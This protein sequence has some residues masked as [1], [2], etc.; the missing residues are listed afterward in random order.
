VDLASRFD[1]DLATRLWAEEFAQ[2][3]DRWDTCNAVTDIG[4]KC[5]LGVLSFEAMD[6]AAES[7]RKHFRRGERHYRNLFR[8]LDPAECSVEWARYLLDAAIR[9]PV[10][11]VDFPIKTPAGHEVGKGPCFG[12]Q[13]KG[14]WSQ[15]CFRAA[16][17]NIEPYGLGAVEKACPY[18]GCGRPMRYW[19]RGR[20]GETEFRWAVD[21]VM[22]HSG[23]GC[24]CHFN[25]KAM[26]PWCNS[27]KGNR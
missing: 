6:D 14:E 11:T 4:A 21:H 16:W 26:H 1:V 19:C 10:P 17:G 3:W 27:S 22:S 9:H 20:R 24:V 18:R 5:G 12:M 23:R 8:E 25:L 13:R 2:G 7:I 15:R